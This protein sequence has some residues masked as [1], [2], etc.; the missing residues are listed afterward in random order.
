MAMME[1]RS[2]AGESGNWGTVRQ[3]AT[4]AGDTGRIRAGDSLADRVRLVAMR[5]SVDIAGISAPQT[6]APAALNF[7]ML[8][9]PQAK[10]RVM[11]GEIRVSMWGQF[12]QEDDYQPQGHNAAEL[13]NKYEGYRG[14]LNADD[15]RAFINW[16]KEKTGDNTLRLPT[17]QEY[18][19]IKKELSEQLTGTLWDR[20]ADNAFRSLSV[21]SRYEDFPENRY[22]DYG[23]RLVGDLPKR[24]T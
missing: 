4:L 23:L 8:V 19:A 5:Q 17:D 3:R 16:A 18:L 21:E 2:R 6:Q 12:A 11:R 22:S 9:A 10:V 1:V 15:C 7:D 20:L 13:R 24:Q 14:F